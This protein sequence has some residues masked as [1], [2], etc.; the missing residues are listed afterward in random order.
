MPAT[1]RQG[2]HASLNLKKN[3]FFL[4]GANRQAVVNCYTVFTVNLF[5]TMHPYRERK[6][7]YKSLLLV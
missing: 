3:Q 5:C 4:D 6:L 2:K 1:S 7:K